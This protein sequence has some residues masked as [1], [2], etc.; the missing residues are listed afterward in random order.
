MGVP[1][2]AAAGADTGVGPGCDVVWAGGGAVGLVA[3]AACGAV[4]T[5]VGAEELAAGGA[6]FARGVSAP[7]DAVLTGAAPDDP[8]PNVGVAGGGGAAVTAL[9]GAEDA[10]AAG[11]VE[12]D[13]VD[14]VEGALAVAGGAGVVAPA[15]GV[16][17]V[18]VSAGVGACGVD[19]V[20]DG[21]AGA[22]G[23]AGVAPRSFPIRSSTALRS[24]WDCARFRIS[25][26]LWLS[27]LVCACD[28]DKAANRNTAV[29]ANILTFITSIPASRHK[30]FSTLVAAG[31]GRNKQ[32]QS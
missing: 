3:G 27:L 6:P 7:G 10:A 5:A 25:R 2:G 17:A 16:A 15:A 11:A 4:V 18:G 30:L 31:T 13:G 32:L 22:G 28:D 29:V 8:A 14:G 12:V 21:A 24:D 23:W 19:T 20:V 26:R 1:T 9:G